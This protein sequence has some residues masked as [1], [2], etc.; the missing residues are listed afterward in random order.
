MKI[1]HSKRFCYFLLIEIRTEFV[2][3]LC[4]KLILSDFPLNPEASFPHSLCVKP[5]HH[6]GPL[7]TF[8]LFSL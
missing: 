7:K 6:M 5:K 3:I 4:C 8:H 1:C 2:T